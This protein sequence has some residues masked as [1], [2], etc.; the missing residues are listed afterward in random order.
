MDGDMAFP[1][2][3]ALVVITNSSPRSVSDCGQA[4][5][6][7][8][9]SCLS[10]HLYPRVSSSVFCR[11]STFRWRQLNNMLLACAPHQRHAGSQSPVFPRS[12]QAII[13]GVA[14]LLFA[15]AATEP[16]TGGHGIGQ[17]IT[18]GRVRVRRHTAP[19]SHYRIVPLEKSPPGWRF[20]G[21]NPPRPAAAGAGRIFT[22]KLSGGRRLF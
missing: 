3:V 6:L 14:S 18:V 21:K 12:V 7:F 10:L 2:S 9:G 17:V 13:I 5:R 11:P 19:V 8:H 20:S 1:V 16:G 4:G 22:D 15:A